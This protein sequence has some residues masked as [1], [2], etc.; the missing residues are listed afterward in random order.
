[1]DEAKAKPQAASERKQ[2]ILK[3]IERRDACKKRAAQ[4]V[5]DLLESPLSE[6]WLLGVL[7][8]L[9][10]QDYQDAVEERAIL[11]LCGYPLCSKKIT[12]MPKQK[13]H[14]CV[15]TKKVYDITH[16]KQYCSN[17][18]YRA[19]TFLKTQLW[20]GPL[21]LRD[22][23]EANAKYKIY[24]E[25]EQSVQ[26]V[27]KDGRGDEVDLGH[28][29]VTK[30]EVEQLP[31]SKP[32]D[33]VKPAK[34]VSPYVTP[35]ALKKLAASIDELRLDD[36]TGSRAEPRKI[37]TSEPAD[38]NKSTTLDADS[39]LGAAPLP[40]HDTE[41]APTWNSRA[42]VPSQNQKSWQQVLASEQARREKRSS[43][44]SESEGPP[45]ER[46]RRALKH[47]VTAETVAHLV[48]DGA[49]R[50]FELNNQPLEAAVR[51]E[52]YREL[53]ASLCKRLDEEERDYERLASAPLDSDDDEDSQVI[54]R[55]TAPVPTL[56]QLQED[57][58]AEGLEIRERNLDDF[59]EK[60][61]ERPA[62]RS[63][64]PALKRRSKNRS[65]GPRKVR[66]KNT[67]KDLSEGASE[68]EPNDVSGA[69][70]PEREPLLPLV[71]SHAQNAHR[72]RIVLHWLRK[73][74]PDVLDML[75]LDLSEVSPYL[76]ELIVTFR[77]SAEN[78]T[79]RL[80]MWTLIA[81]GILL[82]L[83]RKCPA[84]NSAISMEETRRRFSLFL[85]DSGILLQD[86][87]NVVDDI[88]GS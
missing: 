1:M 17:A 7:H 80:E 5:E 15:K 64:S 81:A 2:A 50:R 77:L 40:P 43:T 12:Q 53:Y 19:S 88:L 26:G 71:D 11:L 23:A 29:R 61:V 72:R 60:E 25:E 47:W 86:L 18:C 33:V 51:L 68:E 46:V 42:T 58:R 44:S 49:A 24:R 69:S 85:E 79:F 41:A 4:V 16:R 56:K 48:G 36:S 63:T 22:E 62:K 73:A 3:T 75:Y 21:W 76:T 6:E 83:S 82:M 54:A 78:V 8:E 38:L 13:Y 65:R 14:I 30:K 31:E 28:K 66:S 67:S 39:R 87:T 10:Q 20:D 37:E 9:S 70:T 57:L 59:N 74:L 52:R 45:V 84:L 34:D 55:P 35:E 32:E 27:V